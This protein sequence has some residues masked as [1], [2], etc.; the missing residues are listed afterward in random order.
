VTIPAAI[1]ADVAAQIRD[2]SLR[3]FR[4]VGGW[5]LGRVDFLYDE[6]REQPYV[7]EINTMPGFTDHSV[8]ARAWAES[9]ITYAGVLSELIDL[10]RIRHG[11]PA[12]GAKDVA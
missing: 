1:P 11:L 10:A 3:A 7:L 9:G 8:Y 6:T 5:G 4:A 2:L 12:L